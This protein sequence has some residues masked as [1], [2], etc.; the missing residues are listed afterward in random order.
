MSHAELSP[1]AMRKFVEILFAEIGNDTIYLI[2]S[3]SGWPREKRTLE[4]FLSL[5]AQQA[6]LVYAGLQA[7]MRAYYGRGARGTLMRLGTKSWE[8]LFNELPFGTKAQAGLIRGLPKSMRRKPALEILAGMLGTKRGDVTVHSL[9]L[10]LLVVDSS[11]PAATGQKDDQPICFV[12]LGLIR[13]CLYWA[14]GEE[15]DIE[16]RAC[17]AMGSNQCEFKINIGGR[18]Q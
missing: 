4:Y 1:L 15:H 2:L 6:P 17:K 5:D 14:T 13:E 8:P 10:D 16:E 9:D 18:K 3:K 11:S 12:T 7:A